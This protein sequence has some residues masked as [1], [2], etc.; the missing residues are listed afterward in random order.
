[1]LAG[2]IFATVI[3]L[4]GALIA[5]RKIISSAKKNDDH[6]SHSLIFFGVAIVEFLP[7]MFFVTTLIIIF[8]K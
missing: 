8:V 3:S 6:D 2:A 4:I 5:E 7:I 1:M